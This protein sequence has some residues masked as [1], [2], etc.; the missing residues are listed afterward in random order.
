MEQQ[1]AAGGVV[2]KKDEGYFKVLLIKDSYGYWIWPKGHME[3][4]ETPEETAVR[5]IS[6][7]TGLKD[8]KVIKELGKQQYLFTVQN[9]K[10]F[11]TVHLFL[12]EELSEEN[13]IAQI[14]EIK[15]VRWFSPKEAVEIIGYEGSNVLL[16]K[17]IKAFIRYSRED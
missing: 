9:R 8:I 6:E 4:D 17:G 14:E 2:V 11:K 16:E 13:I 12:V 10:I 1:Y 5:E 3:T 7:E 15:D